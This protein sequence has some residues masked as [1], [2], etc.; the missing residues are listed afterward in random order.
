MKENVTPEIK[1]LIRRQILWAILGVLAWNG[2]AFLE[3]YRGV[4]GYG[5]TPSLVL[6]LAGGTTLM[7]LVTFWHLYR[8][9]T[10]KEVNAMP[11]K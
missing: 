7:H 10:E 8:N 1:R 6:I 11:D 2:Y 3:I 5:L 4:T 9:L